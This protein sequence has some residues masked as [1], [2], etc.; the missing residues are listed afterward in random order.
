M[1]PTRRRL[2]NPDKRSDVEL[3][4]STANSAYP[5]FI[6]PEE[7]DCAGKIA[8]NLGGE[9]YNQFQK[10]ILMYEA[11]MADPTIEKSDKLQFVD[12]LRKQMQEMKEEKE[13]GN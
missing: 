1:E 9:Y 2:Q 8:R 7:L 13:K 12:L 11:I 5:D 10:S 3:A 6:T 4:A